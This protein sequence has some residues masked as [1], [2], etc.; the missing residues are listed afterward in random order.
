[1]QVDVQNPVMSSE[2]IRSEDIGSLSRERGDIEG[3]EES[4]AT[5]VDRNDRESRG[6]QSTGLL[7]H[8]S[9]STHD[10]G[11]IRGCSGVDRV[12]RD[13]AMNHLTCM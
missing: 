3:S 7:D 5:A 9:I 12:L 13:V 4:E 6:K 11:Q 2:W 1:M 10:H 8:R